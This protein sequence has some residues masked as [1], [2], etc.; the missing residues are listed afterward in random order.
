MTS[1]AVVHSERVTGGSINDAW[2]VVMDDGLRVFVKTRDDAAPG[3]YAAEAQGLAWLAQTDDL[4]LPAVLAV[5]D[6]PSQQQEHRF[7][8]LEWVEPGSLDLE[9]QQMLGGG[10]AKLHATGASAFGAGPQTGNDPPQRLG[11]L[12]LPNDPLA[13]WASFYAQRRLIPLI[14]IAVKQGAISSAC[15]RAVE[16]VCERLPT[17][18]GTPEPVAR[19]H[20]DLWNGNV[21][22]DESGRPWLIDPSAHGGHREMDLAMLELFGVPG[23]REHGFQRIVD[24]YQDVWPLADGWQERIGLW[25]LSPLLVHAVLFEGSYGAAVERAARRYTG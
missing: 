18:A 13:D 5:Q 3:E 2:M 20:G 22:A 14:E 24:C 15:A 1:S 19:L 16:K 8:A 17:L 6:P 9:G 25:Q 12:Q 7:L 21:H 11:S 10:L 23:P 4:K